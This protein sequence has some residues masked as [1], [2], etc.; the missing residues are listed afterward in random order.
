MKKIHITELTE[1][2]KKLPDAN[3]K[4]QPDV[5]RVAMPIDLEPLALHTEP[6]EI[7][8]IEME[9]MEFKRIWYFSEDWVKNPKAQWSAELWKL[10]GAGA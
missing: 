7:C 9:I 2:R 10:M 1:L 8:D 4:K 6:T 5:Y 3:D